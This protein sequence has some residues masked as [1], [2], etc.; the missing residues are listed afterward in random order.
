MIRQQGRMDINNN[1]S[2][3]GFSIT[4][5]IN[6]EAYF[7]FERNLYIIDNTIDLRTVWWLANRGYYSLCED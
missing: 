7:I 2:I 5:A 6:F 1:I 4:C 3:Y